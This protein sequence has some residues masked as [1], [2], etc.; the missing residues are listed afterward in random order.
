MSSV[1]DIILSDLRKR[2]RWVLLNVAYWS[3][4]TVSFCSN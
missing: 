4:K 1:L 2:C 3:W